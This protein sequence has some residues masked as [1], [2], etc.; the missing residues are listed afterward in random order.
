MPEEVASKTIM[1]LPG[2]DVIAYAD[3]TLGWRKS[4][5][6]G[7]GGGGNKYNWVDA[8]ECPQHGRWGVQPAGVSKRTGD[9]YDA[10]YT[11]VKGCNNRPGRDWVENNP[12]EEY[13][14]ESANDD[15]DGMD[16]LPF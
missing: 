1:S 2:V 16:D 3:G 4:T 11:C 15:S 6:I 9:A 8:D 10:F 7:G 14:A 5:A 12:A 13:A